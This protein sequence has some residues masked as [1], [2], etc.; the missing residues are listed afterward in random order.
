MRVLVV[1]YHRGISNVADHSIRVSPAVL[2]IIVFV[3]VLLFQHEQGGPLMSNN[4]FRR[5]ISVDSAPRGSLCEWCGKPAEQQLTAIGGSYHNDSGLFCR[6]CG[7]KFA[8]AVA[9]SI[10]TPPPVATRFTTY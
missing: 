3:K 9:N 8:Q 4:E 6:P 10:T 7:E 2:F 5:P 1:P